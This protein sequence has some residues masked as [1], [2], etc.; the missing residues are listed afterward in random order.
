M[1][2]CTLYGDTNGGLAVLSDVFKTKAY[3]LARWINENMEC[4][5]MDGLIPATTITKPPSA[6]LRPD[7]KDQDSLPPYEVLDEILRLYIEEMK[8]VREIEEATGFERALIAK[9]VK[10]IYR[11]EY[12]RKQL[13]PGLRVTKKAFGTGRQMPLA[14]GWA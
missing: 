1:G 13:P 3:A 5:N 2:Y 7:Q 4:K 6:E 14:Q 12:K 10:T 11:N 9:I 8:E